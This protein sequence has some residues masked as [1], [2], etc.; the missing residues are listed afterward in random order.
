MLSI[1]VGDKV[2]ITNDAGRPETG[3]CI[4]IEVV[5]GEKRFMVQVGNVIYSVRM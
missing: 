4:A 1:K 5:R 3:T 2:T